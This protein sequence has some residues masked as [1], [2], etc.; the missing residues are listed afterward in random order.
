MTDDITWRMIGDDTVVGKPAV[1]EAL[2]AMKAVATRELVIHSII[3]DGSEG[4][5]NG[6]IATEAGRS[7]AFC[8]I[9]RFSSASALQIESLTSYAID[10]TKE[11]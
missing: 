7:Y 3:I 10:L 2:E 9:V 8:D 6:V 5:V 11:Q 4:A 1:R